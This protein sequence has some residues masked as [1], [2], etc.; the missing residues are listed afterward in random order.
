MTDPDQVVVAVLAGGLGQSLEKVNFL[1]KGRCS[2]VRL[3]QDGLEVF[4]PAKQYM[5]H[6]PSGK[7]LRGGRHHKF[8]AATR[9]GLL[10]ATK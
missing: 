3:E 8:E 1:V 5:S 4:P 10:C 9:T 6:R 2:I 7:D